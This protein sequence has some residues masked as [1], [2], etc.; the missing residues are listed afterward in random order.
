MYTSVREPQPQPD[1]RSCLS[2]CHCSSCSLRD[3]FYSSSCLFVLLLFYIPQRGV[4]WKQGVVIYMTL[5]T[6]LLYSTTPIHC[7][8]HPLH[9]P[10][11]SIQVVTRHWTQVL[12]NFNPIGQYLYYDIHA[13]L[14]YIYIYMQCSERKSL[15]LA[16]C[17]ICMFLLFASL[18]AFSNAQPRPAT[19]PTS[20]EPH[21]YIYIYIYGHVCV[22]VCVHM[23][24]IYMYISNM[25][26]IHIYIYIY[27]YMYMCIH[28]YIHIFI[29]LFTFT[30]T[31]PT[32]SDECRLTA[33]HTF[34]RPTL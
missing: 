18:L 29:Y 12:D 22:C 13:I 9:P 8:P 11:Q 23:Y 6:S 27:I 26:T 14:I 10:L 33:S 34:W 5:C 30:F 28:I 3:G 32:E 16:R 17:C 1:L 15:L 24:T 4:Q 20:P 2:P 25:Y 31:Y 21:I 19:A 7:T